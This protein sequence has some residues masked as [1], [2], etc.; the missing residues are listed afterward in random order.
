[1]EIKNLVLCLVYIE[2]VN[3]GITIHVGFTLSVVT[4]KV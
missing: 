2:Y 4:E 3:I 1:M